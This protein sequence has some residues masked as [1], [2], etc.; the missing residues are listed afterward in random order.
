MKQ[1]TIKIE[2]M[3]C[4]HCQMTVEKAIRNV[5]GVQ[6]VSV[7]LGSKQAEVSYDPAITDSAAIQSAVTKAGYKVVD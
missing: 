6:D 7:N 1:E 2:G 5:K 3:M 4:G